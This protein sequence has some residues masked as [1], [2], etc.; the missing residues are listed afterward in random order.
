M[1]KASGHGEGR[2]KKKKKK[3]KMKKKKTKKGS[4]SSILHCQNS[5]EEGL[6]PRAVPPS[7]SMI[8]HSNLTSRTVH[9]AKKNGMILWKDIS[10]TLSTNSNCLTW[11]QVSTC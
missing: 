6:D 9:A 11:S 2:K 1:G 5:S 7:N 10:S 3:E 4:H 8:Q